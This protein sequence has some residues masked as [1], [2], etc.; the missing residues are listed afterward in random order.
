[1]EF[2]K[3]LNR[4]IELFIKLVLFKYLKEIAI[5]IP[6]TMI[7]WFIIPFYLKFVSCWFFTFPSAH[8]VGSSIAIPNSY[9]LSL[10][11]QQTYENK[12]D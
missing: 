2:V 11:D 12:D 8:G 9:V 7:D 6:R 5:F 10:A 4:N 1:M 3:Q